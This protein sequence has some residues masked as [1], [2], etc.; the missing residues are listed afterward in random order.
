MDDNGELRIIMD[1]NGANGLS[2]LSQCQRLHKYS[3]SLCVCVVCLVSCAFVSLYLL[4]LAIA[5]LH[6]CVWVFR[7]P[8]CSSPMSP[9][10]TKSHKISKPHTHNHIAH[11]SQVSMHKSIPL[12]PRHTHTHTPL[13]TFG[14]AWERQT[15]RKHTLEPQSNNI[16]KLTPQKKKPRLAQPDP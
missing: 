10:V 8:L 5:S 7:F 6:L 4:A 9:L 13:E 2:G 14:M 12:E 3:L 1:H 16:E 11:P 15:N